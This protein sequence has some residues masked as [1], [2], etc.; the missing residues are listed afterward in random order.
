MLP[1]VSIVN[2]VTWIGTVTGPAL[3]VS[4]PG[5]GRVADD[6]KYGMIQGILELQA[7]VVASG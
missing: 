1:I 6:V 5:C 4:S 3:I 2:T 7:G